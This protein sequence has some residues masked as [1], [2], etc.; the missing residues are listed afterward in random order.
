M[1]DSLIL[2]SIKL[3]WLKP[4]VL[5][6]GILCLCLFGASVLDLRGFE[7]EIYIIPSLVGMLWNAMLF[8]LVNTFPHVP[9][10]PAHDL[11]FFAKFKIRSH[12]FIH[13]VIG[14]AFLILTIALAMLSLKLSSIWRSEI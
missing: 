4:V 13:A 3:R 7:S 6:L 14:F 10:K 12:R 11:R 8:V 5:I 9:P 1:L 2:L